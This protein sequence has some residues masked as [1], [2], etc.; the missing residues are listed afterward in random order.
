MSRRNF[1]DL[2]EE[3]RLLILRTAAQ[4][5]SAHGYERASLNRIIALCGMSKSS[6]YYYFDDKAE[7]FTLLIERAM[8]RLAADMQFPEPERLGDGDYW[9]NVETI[10]DRVAV[11]GT[12]QPWYLAVA[13][14]FYQGPGGAS[15]PPVLEPILANAG[16]WVERALR[17]GQESGAIRTDLPFGLLREAVFAL[18]QAL[19]RWSVLN[20]ATMSADEVRDAAHAQADFL[21]RML[22]PSF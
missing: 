20:A 2:P 13:N 1:V 19:D 12:Q 17:A 3:K 14:L 4:E 9:A 8:T 21:R 7:L 6:F 22:A 16:Q 15:A 11:V 10:F 18:L 5:F